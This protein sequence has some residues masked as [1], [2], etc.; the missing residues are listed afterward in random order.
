M[1]VNKRDRLLNFIKQANKAIYLNLY[2]YHRDGKHRSIRLI[3]NKI[4]LIKYIDKQLTQ[5][6]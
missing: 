4:Y 6:L 3:N 2:I 1:T 5:N